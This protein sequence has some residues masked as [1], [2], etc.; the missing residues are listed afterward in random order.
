MT[1]HRD[2]ASL[3]ALPRLRLPSASNRARQD[4]PP[5]IA[6]LSIS[7]EDARLAQTRRLQAQDR[8]RQATSVAPPAFR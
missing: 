3:P 7:V 2:M 6:P 1:D 4:E 5:T 8:A